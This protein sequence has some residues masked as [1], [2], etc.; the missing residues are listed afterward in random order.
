MDIEVINRIEKLDSGELFLGLEGSGK[1]SY[2]YIYRAAS[3]V[4]WD[5]DEKG[6]KSTQMKEWNATKWFS[7]IRSVVES[8]LGVSL[9]IGSK[10]SW[11]GIEDSE[12]ATI[13]KI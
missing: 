13:E 7:Q 8:E 6:F 2:Q 12:Q 9:Q 11:V 10:V 1:P 4:Y 5:Q 3:G